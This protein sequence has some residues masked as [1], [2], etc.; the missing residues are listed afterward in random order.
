MITACTIVARNY[1]AHARVLAASFLETHPGGECFV[2][3]TDDEQRAFDDRAEPFRCLRL[4]EVGFAARDIET[5]AG[6]YDVI[7][8]ATA[9]KPQFLRWLLSTGRDSAVY[10]DPDVKVF[11][12]LEEAIRLARS[13]GI[14]LTPHTM[15]PVPRDDRQITALEILRA[16]MF[17]LGFIAIGRSAMPFLEWWWDNTRRDALVDPARMLFTDQRWID[18]VPCLFEHHILR[19]P[20]WNVAY[21]NLHGRDMIWT[22][23]RYEVN[24]VRL[25]FFHFSGFDHR[26]PHLLSRHQGNAPRILLSEHPAVARA[27]AEYVAD[28]E[29]AGIDATSRLEYG[30]ARLP[31]GVTLNRHIR[32]LYRTALLAHERQRGPEPVHPFDTQRAGQFIDWLNEQDPDGP[33]GLSRYL[34]SVYKSRP[35]LQEAFPRVDREDADAY[36]AWLV[37]DGIA[38]ENIPAALCQGLG[39]AQQA[40][41]RSSVR[42]A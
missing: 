28:L 17:N 9:V 1:L 13:H 7:E 27:C 2:L 10:L 35:D 4:H 39:L 25:R 3:I 8:L 37:R 30:W 33:P 38:E 32:R 20:G 36:R 24:R 14:V 29:R 34:H 21:W 5:L 31:S 41:P 15:V 16:G 22:S 40:G 42:P 19:D 26:Q 6:I 23:G 11:G 12:D 18:F